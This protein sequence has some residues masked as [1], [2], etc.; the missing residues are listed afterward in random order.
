M[1]SSEHT[2]HHVHR[3]DEGSRLGMWLFLFTELLLFG[4]MFLLFAVYKFLHYEEFHKAATELNTLV[5]TL[6]T[7]ILLTSSLTMALS[8]TAL[9]KGKRNLSILLQLATIAMAFGFLINKYVEWSAKISHGIYPG[10]EDLLSRGNGEILFFGLYYV[11]T[12]LHALHV[13]IGVAII[14]VMTWFTARRS[15][16]PDNYVRLEAAGLYWHLVDIIW[17]FLFPLFYL[18]S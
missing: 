9:Q 8:I 6:N 17:I 11:M 5:G 14:G 15:I 18:I 1:S 16:N 4:G 12:G 2:I 10:S 13:V 3:D 7:V